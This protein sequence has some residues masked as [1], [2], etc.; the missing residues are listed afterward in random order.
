LKF[1][2]TRALTKYKL[3]SAAVATGRRQAAGMDATTEALAASN[4]DKKRRANS[5]RHL[6]ASE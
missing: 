5:R 2:K 3:I 1:N 4:D 6:S